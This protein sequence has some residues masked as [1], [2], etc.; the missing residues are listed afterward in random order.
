MV[1]NHFHEIDANRQDLA[2]APERLNIAET[3]LKRSR[4]RLS[5][6]SMRAARH[7]ELVQARETLANIVCQIESLPPHDSGETT[8]EKAERDAIAAT[9]RVINAQREGEAQR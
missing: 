6:L 3:R 1:A 2:A 8:E 4:E 9:R 7:G 5:K